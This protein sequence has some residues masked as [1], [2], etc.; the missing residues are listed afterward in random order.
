MYPP[1]Y[2]R[3]QL[4][5]DPF[6]R[7]APVDPWK[8][9]M[10]LRGGLLA[11]TTWALDTINIMLAD[12]QTHTHF[13]LKQMPGLLQALV[14]IYVKCL[15]ELF[16]EFKSSPSNIENQQP[17]LNDLNGSSHLTCTTVKKQDHRQPDSIIY[18]VESNSLNKYRRK[19]NKESSIVYDQVYDDEGN[20]K[21]NPTHVS[22]L[23]DRCQFTIPLAV[24]RFWTFKI[25]MTYAT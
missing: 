7:L 20:V 1:A 21:K 22:Y 10:S 6:L 25:R 15:T 13:R 3:L 12:D 2:R 5:N 4:V 23:T 9:M 14:D 17:S 11:E 8:L 18:R 16:D 19:Y 24:L